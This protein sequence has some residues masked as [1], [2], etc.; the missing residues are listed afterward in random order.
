[1]PGKKI[2]AYDTVRHMSQSYLYDGVDEYKMEFIRSSFETL[3]RTLPVC[4]RS[5]R[6]LVAASKADIYD[7]GYG[8][9]IRRYF[10]YSGDLRRFWVTDD[11]LR[12][13]PDDDVGAPDAREALTELVRLVLAEIPCT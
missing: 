3:A 13:L 12:L 6:L 7:G 8:P 4:R 5:R 11:F 10:A 9:V 2:A 1:M